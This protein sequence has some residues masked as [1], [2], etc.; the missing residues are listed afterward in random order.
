MLRVDPTDASDVSIVLHALTVSSGSNILALF[1]PQAL[2]GWTFSG[3]AIDGV[4]DGLRLHSTSTD[5]I[6]T[7]SVSIPLLARGASWTKWFLMVNSPD[8]M[9]RL[10]SYSLAVLILSFSVDSARRL[11]PILLLSAA[12]VV[13]GVLAI[14]ARIPDSPGSAAVAVSRATVM[15]LSNRPALGASMAIIAAAILLGGIAA[16]ADRH[17]APV[18]P[19]NPTTV[20]RWHGIAALVTIA[21]ITAPD[22]EA[23]AIITSSRQY[24]PN[25]DSDNLTYWTYLISH[26]R[27]PLRDFWYPYGGTAVFDLPFPAGPLL[28]WVYH[29]LLFGMFFLVVGRWR[30]LSGAVLG[31]AALLA[32]HLLGLLPGVER[33]L[34]APVVVLAYMTAHGEA[35]SSRLL[36]WITSALAL[37]IEPPQLVYAAVPIGLIVI[38]DAAKRWRTDREFSRCLIRRLR[39]DFGIPAVFALAV[40]LFLGLT[41]QLEGYLELYGRLGDAVAYSTWRSGLPELTLT[42]FPRILGLL[43]ASAVL[44]AIGVYEYLRGVATRAYGAAL[45][46]VGL[47]TLMVMQ[48][49]FMRWM[50]DQLLT[51]AAVM[52]IVLLVAWPGRRGKTEYVAC[53]IVM[54]AF[55]AMLVVRP[56]AGVDVTTIARAPSRLAGVVSVLWRR[57]ALA[58]TVN[59]ARFAPERFDMY[60]LERRAVETI[61]RHAGPSGDVGVFALTDEMSVYLL[62]GQRRLWISNMYDASPLPRQTKVVEWLKRESPPYVVFNVDHLLFDGFQ[63]VVRVPLVYAEVVSRY[64]PLEVDGKMQVLRLRGAAEPLALSYWRD[65]LGADVD[66]GRLASVSSFG[67]RNCSGECGDLLEV[68][69]PLGGTGRVTVPITAAGLPFSVSFTR[70]PGETTY[71][72]LLDRVWFWNAAKRAG[73]PY[74]LAQTPDPTLQID[75]RSVDSTIAALY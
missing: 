16:F 34:L 21:A 65:R 47:V 11:Y 56:T 57:Q 20:A 71:R 72:L 30:G 55:L 44:V 63:M 50:D 3:L 74:G 53:G 40:L 62:A 9:W 48:K 12:A 43:L 2:A 5:P 67:A 6:L 10:T 52:V 33:Y 69:A 38:A 41:G 54:G 42:A 18:E 17:R 31:T 1:G 39:R 22:L 8:T 35:Y 73:L 70:V 24:V 13:L 26:G 19:N 60:V 46:G 49:H 59:A 61:R 28:R 66:V 15:G 23:W 37:F 4:D 7:T 14:Q 27:W 29:V 51:F 32:G 75:V 25:W 36:F 68:H 64:V 58:P 45:T